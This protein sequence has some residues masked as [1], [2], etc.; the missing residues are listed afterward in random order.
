[1][2]RSHQRR[3]TRLFTLIHG[4]IDTKSDI[5]QMLQQEYDVPPDALQTIQGNVTTLMD[6]LRK[7]YEHTITANQTMAE[8]S[9]PPGDS[10]P[11]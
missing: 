5:A 8:R 2:K 3:L 6:H 9:I 4:S 10:L 7:K 11:E 1:M